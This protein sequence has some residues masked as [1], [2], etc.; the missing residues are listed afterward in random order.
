M[1]PPA[2]LVVRLATLLLTALNASACTMDLEPMASSLEDGASEG[3]TKAEEAALVEKADLEGEIPTIM[4]L[5]LE[6]V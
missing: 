4:A 5:A 2:T 1:A 6:Q 3:V